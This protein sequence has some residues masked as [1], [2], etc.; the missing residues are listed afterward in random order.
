VIALLKL[1]LVFAGIVWLLNRKWNLGLVLALAS[2]AAGLLFTYP[3]P[4]IIRDALLTAIDLLTLRLVLIVVLIMILG[5]MLRQTAST[6]GM[7]EA[8]QALIPSGR[9]VIA[10]LPAMIGLLPMVGGAMFSAPMVDEVGDRLEA[11]S[12]RKTFVNY[13]FRHIWEPIF[14]LYPS[15]LLAAEL[16]DLTPRQLAHATWPLA[17]AALLGGLLFGLL[18]LPRQ[19]NG[20][21]PHVPRA[22]SLRRL[23]ASIWPIVLVVTLSF[24]L[25]VDERLT[26]ILSLLVT[27][28]LTMAVK[29]IPPHD[30][31]TILR[32]RIP[33]K[34][35]IV[36]FGALIFRRV[37]ESSG[38]VIAVS[39]ALTVLNIPL[40]VIAFGAP[41][42]AGLLTGLMAAGFSIGFPVTLAVIA[43][44]GGSVAPGWAAWLL[45]GGFIGTMLSPVHLC[46]GLTRVYFKAEWSP[47]YRLLAPSALLV[48]ATAAGM[49]LLDH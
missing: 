1:V 20:D 15:M 40:A 41:F 32:E 47:I 17:V 49:L 38:A 4:E 12:A 28:T 10:A 46:L 22:Q 16:M 23:T 13:W 27:I 43:A 48:T 14:P 34:T 44:D 31:T 29:H 11:N 45:A 21:L 36:I 7:V 25:P 5:E 39:E 2:I 33:W 37:L 3:L 8:L 19:G 42:I 30:L 6:K 26:L 9:I 24:T 18:G 35:V